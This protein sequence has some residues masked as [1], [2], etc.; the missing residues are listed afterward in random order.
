MQINLDQETKEK[1]ADED[2]NLS[3]CGA[4]N[5]TQSFAKAFVV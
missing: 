3:L 1:D 2:A 4:I 5:W